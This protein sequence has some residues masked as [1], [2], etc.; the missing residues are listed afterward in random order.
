MSNHGTV[1]ATLPRALLEYLRALG[2]DDAAI[3]REAE[4]RLDGADG[5]ARVP[6]ERVD[7]L[8]EIA[9]REVAPAVGVRFALEMPP[10]NAG[11]LEVVTQSAPSVEASLGHVCRYWYLLND[12]VDLAIGRAGGEVALTLRTRSDEPLAPPWI[13]LTVV[14]L[15]VIGAR[16]IARPLPPARIALPYPEARSVPELGAVV[17][18]PLV[19]DA[20]SMAIVYPEA[21]LERSML[22]SNAPLHDVAR[23]RR[24]A[25]RA[26]PRRGRSLRAREG[27]RRGAARE[28]GRDARSHRGRRGHERA[29]APAAAEGVGHEPPRGARRRAAGHRDARARTR[30]AHRDRRRLFARILRNERVRPGI[31]PLDG[32]DARRVPQESAPARALVT[33]S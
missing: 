13:D 31:S 16:S 7:A 20:P 2:K 9:V 17:G 12:G 3:A 10:G 8:W 5:D 4:I 27:R 15:A 1:L 26:P 30:D 21:I 22:A 28:R 32:H 33:L 11:V 29:H 25:A 14:A 23:A 24:L 18:A 6:R 19:F